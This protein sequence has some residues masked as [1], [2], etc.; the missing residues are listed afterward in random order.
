MQETTHCR[1]AGIVTGTP[2]KAEA[3]KEKYAIPEKNIYDYDNFDRIASDPDI[4]VVYVVLPN[5]MHAEFTIR[6]AKAGK[7]VICEKPMAT[8]VEDAQRMIEACQANNVLLGIGYRLQY[9][10]HH[11]RVMELGQQQILGKV[12]SIKNNFSQPKTDGSLDIWRLDK[13]LAGGGPLM[14]L[15]VYCVQGACYTLGKVPVAVTARFEDVTKPLYFHSVEESIS[16]RMEFE[17][18]VVAECECSYNDKGDILSGTAENGWWRIEPSYSYSGKKGVTS[19]GPM[20]LP[21]VTE[22]V[23][24]MDAQAKSFK[25]GR[26]PIASGEMGLRDMKILMAIYE[27]ARNEGKR[28]EIK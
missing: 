20:D 10:P 9:E 16:W 2:S 7:H 27:S 3:W 12:K 22:Q 6:A 25:E 1:L 26:T 18:G 8:S 19:E 15:G 21:E 13:E 11:Q 4:D 5:S 23:L 17:D 24:Q 28:V 14:D